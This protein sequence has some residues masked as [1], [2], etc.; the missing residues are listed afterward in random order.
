MI[1]DEVE[2]AAPHAGRPPH[3]P[4]LEGRQQ[5]ESLSGLGMAQESIAIFM[6]L[7]KETLLKHYGAEME[8][9]RVKADVQVAKS[10]FAKAVSNDH[11]QSMAAAK[12]WEQTRA[13]RRERQEMHHSGAVGTYDAS[14]LAGLSDEELTLFESVLARLSPGIAAPVGGE[15][16]DSEAGG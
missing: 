10:V 8:M 4:T 15:S 2:P 9:G 1:A 12:W 6:G 5:V 16:G 13:G 3:V 11:P 7:A 14:K